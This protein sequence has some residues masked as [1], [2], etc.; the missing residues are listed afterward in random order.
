MDLCSFARI[1]PMVNQVELHP[2]HQQNE[3]RKWMEKYG[4]QVEAWAPFGEGRCGMFENP[5]L[6]KIGAKY[7]RTVAQVILRWH[8][9]QGTVVIP[10]STHIERMQENFNVFDFSLSDEDMAAVSALDTAQSSFFSHEDPAMVEWFV[11]MVTERRKN[12]D[13]RQEKKNW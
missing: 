2:L 13:S 7:G 9:Q 12:H 4:V 10:K 8:L 3:A 6:A 11:S 5:V 1:C